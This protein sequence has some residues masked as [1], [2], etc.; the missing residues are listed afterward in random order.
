M[1]TFLG[2]G[3][4]VL[5]GGIVICTTAG[6]AGMY[7]SLMTVIYIINKY[8]FCLYLSLVVIQLNSRL[9]TTKPFI[10]VFHI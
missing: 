8:S 2:A 5:L 10:I 9:T 1:L 6:Q 3:E 7:A 4:S